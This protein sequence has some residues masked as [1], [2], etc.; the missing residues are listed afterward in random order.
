MN[1]PGPKIAWPNQ[2][3]N[4]LL[5]GG[6]DFF[7]GQ[8]SSSEY[9]AST[10]KCIPVNTRTAIIYVR[11]MQHVPQKALLQMVLRPLVLAAAA[12]QFSKINPEEQLRAVTNQLEMMNWS[13]ALLVLTAGAW[14]ESTFGVLDGSPRKK[15]K[16]EAGAKIDNAVE[17]TRT[18]ELRALLRAAVADVAPKNSMTPKTSLKKEEV[19]DSA[20]AA[21]SGYREAAK[22]ARD[23]A[24]VE[25]QKVKDVEAEIQCK[26]EELKELR[27]K[28]TQARAEELRWNDVAEAQEAEAVAAEADAQ[29]AFKQEDGSAVE[30]RQ[31]RRSEEVAS[32]TSK[33]SK[34]SSNAR[35]PSSKEPTSP[36]S[37]GAIRLS[38]ASTFQDC[39]SPVAQPM[40]AR[41]LLNEPGI[42]CVGH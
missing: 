7:K 21:A 38:R 37:P 9:L 41:A 26:E 11:Q 39:E 3:V 20:T 42:G 32:K 15:V 18:A 23:L 2:A 10:K 13:G 6:Q 16:T 22:Q 8:K 31:G 17:V 19:V 28:L 30:A 5:L 25:A 24:K 34:V 27:Q 35:S 14:K 40:G 12:W 1:L 33:A 29:E 36:V 4:I